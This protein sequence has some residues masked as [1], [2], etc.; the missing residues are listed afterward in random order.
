[1]PRHRMDSQRAHRAEDLARGLLLDEVLPRLLR[2]AEEPRE[3]VEEIM[4][5]I[6]RRTDVG[7]YG[8]TRAG[9]TGGFAAALGHVRQMLDEASRLEA[10]RRLPDLGTDGTP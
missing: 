4:K 1:M 7:K 5:A 2:A 9:D 6:R 3:L 8:D 10:T